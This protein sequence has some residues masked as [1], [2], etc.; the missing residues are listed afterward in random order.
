MAELAPSERLQPCLLDRLTDDQPQQKAESREKRV[1]SIKQ[2][3]EA[4]LRDLQF[5]LNTSAPIHLRDVGD[6]FSEIESS[7]LN[8]GIRDLTGQ[9]ATTSLEDHAARMIARSVQAFEPRIRRK[10]VAVR[11]DRD[12]EAQP[13]AGI[14]FSIEGELWA[15]RL[16]ERLYIKTHVD[17]DT[18]QVK[19]EGRSGG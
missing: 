3:R 14:A 16:Q 7:V 19:L 6:E 15:Q 13:G 4:V 18:G 8:Y 17:L 12:K 9:T 11:V 10:S 1:F 2:I 5:L